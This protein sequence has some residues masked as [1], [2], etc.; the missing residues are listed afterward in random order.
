MNI[1]SP[2]INVFSVSIA[3]NVV[4]PFPRGRLRQAVLMPGE[5]AFFM[6]VFW[7]GRSFIIASSARMYGKGG[8]SAVW[9]LYAHIKE[10]I[11]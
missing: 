3:L 8:R 1:L 7:N 10:S 4:F 6:N 11:T 9:G 2:G 5:R